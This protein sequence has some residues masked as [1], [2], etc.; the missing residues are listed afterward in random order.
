MPVKKRIFGKIV[1]ALGACLILGAAALWGCNQWDAMRAEETV[2]DT[3]SE[4]AQ[5]I[6]D[7]TVNAEHSAK[8]TAPLAE[9]PT[10]E[11]DG[12]DY[13]GVLEIPALELE[14]PVISSW[15]S[16][17]AKTAPCRYVGSAYTD[18]MIICAHNYRSHL[19]KLDSLDAGDSVVF[20]DMEGNRFS[21]R[22]EELEVLD[23]TAI[24]QMEAGDWDLTL[25]TCTAGGEARLT[26][27][28]KRTV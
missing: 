27:R 19:G 17:N 13:V 7:E 9:M 1:T 22:I 20:V 3:M 12:I 6:P 23:G 26:V 10:Q 11:I 5:I 28:C 2:S 21:Y 15:S 16:S 4:L 8:E 14:L 25:F 24:E 18:D